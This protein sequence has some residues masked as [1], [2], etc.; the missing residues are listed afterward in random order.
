MVTKIPLRAPREEWR[1]IGLVGVLFTLQIGLMNFGF[2]ATTG[3]NGAVLIATNPLFALLFAHFLIPGDRIRP[4]RLL[5]ASI[6]FAGTAFV[7]TRGALSP[8]GAGWNAGD[9]IV[10]SSAALLGL[11]LA[12]SGRFLK[13]VNEVRLV[14]WMMLVSLPIFGVGGA[15]FE[16]ILW[17]KVGW[18]AVSGIVYQG[19][20]V[21]GLGFSV[22]HYLIRRYTPSVMISFNFISPVVGVA[23][24][25]WILGEPV[26][27]SVLVG[28]ALVAVGL[29]LIARR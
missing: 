17:D 7:L 13:S 2:A 1:A 6:A 11:R 27:S 15:V 18:Q 9:M 16:T 5:G 24:S 28:M 12:L 21:A 29:L 4:L 14:F 26:V 8:S 25:I 20:V 19:V 23:L 22:T 3:T 10:L